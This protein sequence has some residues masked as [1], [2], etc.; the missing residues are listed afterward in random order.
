VCEPGLYSIF[1]RF[2]HTNNQNIY[3]S[4]FQEIEAQI[5]QRQQEFHAIHTRFDSINEQL[6][7][8]M[9]IASNHSKQFT[10]LEHQVSEMND[11]LR[12][13]KQTNETG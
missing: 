2:T 11:A 9:T 10:H 1:T 3:N 6:L 7:R 8:N 5:N 4:K 13:E 12:K